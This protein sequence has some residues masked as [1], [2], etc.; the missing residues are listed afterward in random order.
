MQTDLRQQIMALIASYGPAVLDMS[1]TVASELHLA[2]PGHHE[3]VEGAVAAL[4]HGVVHYLL[5][6]AETGKLETADIPT[7]VSRLCTEAGLSQVDA[8]RA[9]TMWAEIIGAIHFSLATRPA[10]RKEPKGLH[11]PFFGLGEVLIVGMAGLMG[12][13]LPW[14]IALEDKRGQHILI[15]ME[16]DA[17]G[18]HA[19]LNLLG[20]AGGFLGAALGWMVGSPRSLDF[21]V[22]RGVASTRRLISS[23]LAAALGSFC[24]LWVGYHHLADIGTFSGALIG[25]AVATFLATVFTFK[26]QPLGIWGK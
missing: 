19:L 1:G 16:M 8:Q 21:Q 20:A 9:V 12:S 3:E 10:W 15:P 2:L 14:L 18:A 22:N 4:R 11:Q 24:G 23:S 25:S 17:L 5:V 6:L 13:M 26:Y 7:Q